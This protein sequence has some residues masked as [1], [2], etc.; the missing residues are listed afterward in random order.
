MAILG[1]YLCAGLFRLAKFNLTSSK[2]TTS[3]LGLPT[4]AAA[5]F[6]ATLV[7]YHDWVVE[8][9][10]KFLFGKKS[11]LALILFIAILMV[12]SISFPSFKRLNA[13][14]HLFVKLA[15]GITLAVFALIRGV[16]LLFMALLIYIVASFATG[17][18]LYAYN[19]WSSKR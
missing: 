8:S 15:I 4:T 13:V 16:P 2:Q 7:L 14:P 6:I 11:I 19:L 1:F 9:P 18:Y 10:L 12:S 17:C 5:F 3:F